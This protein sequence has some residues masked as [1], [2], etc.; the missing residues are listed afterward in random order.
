[1]NLTAKLYV[2]LAL[3]SLTVAGSLY[4]QS[5]SMFSG[6]DVSSAPTASTS[7]SSTASDLPDEPLAAEAVYGRRMERSGMN[8]EYQ[9]HMYPFTH[10]A[11]AVTSGLDGIGFQVATPLSNKWNLR[12]GVSFLDTNMNFHVS[13]ATA[14]NIYGA[15]LQSGSVGVLVKPRFF[16]VATSLD[17]YPWYGKFRIS[18]GLTLYNGNRGSAIATVAGG[19]SVDLG[20]GTYFSDPKD[21]ITAHA[22]VNM[23]KKV[24][25]RLTIGWGNMLPRDGR[26]FSFPFE[27][28]FEYIG[29]PKLALSLAGSECDPDG[30]CDSI[31]LDPSTKT[32]L[33]EEQNEINHDIGILRF[34]PIVS[35]G[36]SYRF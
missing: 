32:N 24:A 15:T 18:P 7:S 36:V 14:A 28:G 6:G 4:G 3:V 17:W 25:P 2:S 27:I 11:F 5:A 33:Q 23:G 12:A 20:D 19:Q 22:V 21:P 1:M 13:E 9:T 34:Y 30:E 35:S 16:T 31:L 26:H 10:L 8:V 29:R